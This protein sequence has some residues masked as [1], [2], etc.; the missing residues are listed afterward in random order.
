MDMTDEGFD[1]NDEFGAIDGE[2]SA[3]ESNDKEDGGDDDSVTDTEVDSK[4]DSS[5]KPKRKRN[6]DG[7][8]DRDNSKKRKKSKSEDDLQVEEPLEACI[9]C[10]IMICFLQEYQFVCIPYIHRFTPAH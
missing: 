2:T 5:E 1:D 6:K 9:Y 8:K 3:S 10:S 7:C 4:S